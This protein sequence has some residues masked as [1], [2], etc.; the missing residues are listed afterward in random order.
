MDREIY[1]HEAFQRLRASVMR[2]NEK[3]NLTRIVGDEDFRIKNVEDSLEPLF[4]SRFFADHAFPQGGKMIDVGTG[5]GFPLLPLA[6]YRQ[7]MLPNSTYSYYG[8]DSVGKK[9]RALAEIAAEL[10][11][12]DIHFVNGRAELSGRDPQLREHFNLATCRAVAELPVV[13][14]YCSPF[15]KVGGILAIYKAKTGGEELSKSVNAVRR[16]GLRHMESCA[17]ALSQQFGERVV[18]LFRKV[19]PISGA[20]P[21][22]DGVPK[23]SPLS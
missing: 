3:I 21:R 23:K 8:L 15:V 9:M 17:Y 7:L 4:L 13:L 16:L 20:F 10:M 19:E 22:K 5:G 14:E 1:H 11:I 6:I 12:E 18:F 2:M